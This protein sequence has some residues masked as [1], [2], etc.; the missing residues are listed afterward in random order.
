MSKVVKKIVTAVAIVAAVVFTG[1]TALLATIGKALVTAAVSIGVSRLIAKRANTAATAGDIGG[2]RVQLPPATSN[3]LPIIYG[4][5]FVG[6][7][8]TDAMLSTDQ[9]TMWYVVALAEVS[10]NQGGG[11]GSYTFDTNKCYYD[12]KQIQFASPTDGTV[13]G[14]ITNTTPAQIDTRCNG[15]LYV[16]LFT[17]GRASGINTGGQTAD[18]ILSVANG[19]PAAQA[20]TISQAMTNCAFAIVKVIYSTDAGTTG[21]GALMVNMTNSITKP[22]DAILDY[23]LNDRYGCALPID[24][25]D[26][27]SLTALNAYSDEL[28]TYNTATGSPPT[29]QQARYRL[30][31]PL[32]TG[33]NCLDNLQFLV[34]SCDSWL[35]YSELTGKW[36]VVINKLYDGY[37]TVTG[38][39]AVNSSNLIGGIEVSPIDLN[40]TYN[41]IEVAYPNTNIKDQTDYYIIDLFTE[42]PQLLSANEAVNRLNVTLPLVN[43][44]VQARYLAARRIYQSREDLV[45][46]FRLDYSGI[47]LE[48]GDVIRVTHEVY[49][50][51]NKLFRVNNVAETKDEGGNLYADIQAFEYSDGIYADVVTDYIPSFNT[52]LKDP[53]VISPP[54]TPNVALNPDD[55]GTVSSFTVQSTVPDT[56]LVLY[57]DFNYGNNGNVQQHRLYRTLQQSN[58]APFTNSDSANSVYN[59]ASISINDLPAGTYYWSLTARNNTSGKRSNASSPF[60]WPGAGINQANIIDANGVNSNGNVLTSNVAIPTISVNANVYLVSGTGQLANNTYVTG[61]T[62]NGT[63]TIFTVTPTPITPLVNANIQI[64][65]GGIPGEVIIPN[66]LPGNRVTPNSLSGNT[67]I[68]NTVD[69]NVII[70]NTLYGNAIIA[71]TVNGNVII[72]NTLNGNVIQANT[73]NG[74]T[75]QANTIN[76]NTIIA[77]T[78][79][80]NTIVA[81][82]LNGNTIVANSVN[83]NTIIANTINGGAIIANTIDGNKITA[84]TITANQIAANAIST[85]KIQANAISSDKIQANAITTIKIAANTVTTEQL[86]IGSVT[87]ARSSIQEPQVYPV[88]FTNIGNAWP[89]NT[90]IIVPAGGVTIIPTT[91]PTSSANTE[92]QEGSRILVGFT[93]KIYVD[94]VGANAWDTYNCI[95]LWKS[96]A[97][98][99]FDSGL[100]TV[101]HSYNDNTY[102]RTQTIHAYGFGSLDLYSSDG[103]N[104]WGTFSNVAAG[105]AIITGAVNYAIGSA[106]EDINTFNVGPLQDVDNN[107]SV[108][109]AGQRSGTGGASKLD[110]D[111]NL[112]YLSS[113]NLQLDMNALECVPGTGLNGPGTNRELLG[114]ADNGTIFWSPTGTF[115]TTANTTEGVTSLYKNYNAVFANDS[116]GTQYTA[117]AVGQTG[118]IVRS[119]RTLNTN[120][121]WSAKTTQIIGNTPLLTDLYGVGGDNSGQSS[122]SKWVAVGQYGMIQVS[123]DDG[124]QWTQV[125]SPVLTNLNQVR[126]GNGVWVVVGDSGVILKNTGNIQLANNWIQVDTSNLNWANG[127]SYG[128][129]ADRNLMTIDYSSI[130]DKFNIGGIGILLNSDSSNIVP[131]VTY[132]VAPSEAYDL[133]RMTYFGSWANVQKTTQPPVEQRVLNN[134]VFSYTIIDTDYVQGQETTYYLVVGNMAGKQ[135]YVGQ[136]YLNVQE[137]KR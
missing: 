21:A 97:S 27:A 66:T 8:I 90:R 94:P 45:I 29:A 15:F 110:L 65:T 136:A 67:I 33:I 111:E 40:E 71:N 16:Y 54:G 72:A 53:N 84:N 18:Q 2:S 91:D 52:G 60:V 41:Q 32:D 47:Q 104:T 73:I 3:K 34:D 119:S 28:I 13:T 86:I 105:N 58:G 49:G 133:T 106:P 115:G 134:Q 121:T 57:M 120:G 30:N 68:G 88:P 22:G 63:P 55:S 42:D 38:L 89:A 31:G 51:T 107:G 116:N 62:S 132:E 10:D 19:V 56:G 4:T 1:G 95:E 78:L 93:V 127:S 74:N 44:A 108:F 128:N 26:T 82:T 124:D 6:G 69:G 75:I 101:R 81:N 118:T 36:K 59:N 39:F 35:Q 7:S 24:S 130:Y 103:G 14:L 129:I 135:V 5:S 50:W 112:P 109:C 80:G 100:N 20:W 61:V 126:Y 70:G 25:I 131:K 92:Y 137:Y 17:N 37:P 48:A 76:G 9:K 12:G 99:Q 102:G 123:V 77:N 79:N 96:G 11:G 64:I 46:A 113:T 43:N 117:I 114:V 122:T 87:Q 98:E 23:M 125:L 85:D 83:G